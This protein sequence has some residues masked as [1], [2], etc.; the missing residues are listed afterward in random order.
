[1]KQEKIETP[2]EAFSG[3][4]YLIKNNDKRYFRIRNKV[5]Y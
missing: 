1:M 2:I 3:E 5:L 4:G